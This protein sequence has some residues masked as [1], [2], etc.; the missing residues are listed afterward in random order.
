MHAILNH[1]QV[2]VH[3]ALIQCLFVLSEW[4]FIYSFF[5]FSRYFVF[6][7]KSLP[8]SVFLF[9]QLSDVASL[10]IFPKWFGINWHQVLSNLQKTGEKLTDPKLCHSIYLLQY[11]LFSI[12]IYHWDK[13][14]ETMSK[15]GKVFSKEKIKSRTSGKTKL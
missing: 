11:L 7:L 13:L 10:V 8:S 1:L 5:L 9:F 4:V 2:S 3:T 12:S 14:N 15:C 6:F